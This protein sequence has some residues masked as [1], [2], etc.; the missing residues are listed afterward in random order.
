MQGNQQALSELNHED[1]YDGDILSAWDA[2]QKL[3]RE[4]LAVSPLLVHERSGV[5]LEALRGYFDQALTTTNE[6]AEGAIAELKRVGTVRQIAMACEAAQ[7]ALGKDSSVEEVLSALESK[8][9]RNQSLGGQDSAQDGSEVFDSVIAD[10]QDRLVNGRAAGISTGLKELDKAILGLMGGKM[11]VIAA[12]PSM[13]KTALTG[14]I[15]RGVLAQGF[16]VAEFNLEMPPEELVER[17]L[18]WQASVSLRKLISAKGVSPEEA[19]AVDALKG[20]MVRGLW[21]IDGL[22]TSITS[23]RR[24]AKVFAHQLKR[25]GKQLKL[26]ILDYIQL[27]GENGEGREQTVAAISRGCK[28]MAK[29]LNCTVIAISQ[30]N[31][32]CEYRDDK[33]P[34]MSDLR[35]SG[36]IEQDADIIG[37]IYREHV[38]DESWP[39]EDAE[40]IIRKQRNGPTGTVR[41][42]F[43]PKTASF[44]NEPEPVAGGSSVQP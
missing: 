12:R 40:F 9:Y 11:V 6:E 16:G 4:G 41:L 33:R 20:S 44:V 28:L 35:E 23:I 5:N 15:R 1:F 30:L 24:K 8:L 29:E 37:F 18:A 17:E 38:Y 14:T 42:K 19:M 43:S 26:V 10:F 25:K 22:T 13:G 3:S 27:A 2:C 32:G 7:K 39:A 36:A 31:R 34:I 21:L